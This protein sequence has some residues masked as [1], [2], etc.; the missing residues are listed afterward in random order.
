MSDFF[1]LLHFPLSDNDGGSLRST[2][3]QYTNI[4][5]FSTRLLAMLGETSS[6]FIDTDPFIIYFHVHPCLRKH[7][8]GILHYVSA[9]PTGIIYLVSSNKKDCPS[10]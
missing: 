5:A 10:V 8:I 9:R 1:S 2:L 6:S 4:F 7:V 3:L